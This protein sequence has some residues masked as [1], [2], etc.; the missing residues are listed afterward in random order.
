MML[1]CSEALGPALW[2]GTA[3]KGTRSALRHSSAHPRVLLKAGGRGLWGGVPGG[4]QRSI[5]ILWVGWT[6]R[7]PG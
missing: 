4:T 2:G 5:Q 7:S 3:G 6:S 1:E